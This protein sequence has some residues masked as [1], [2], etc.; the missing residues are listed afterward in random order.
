MAIGCW[1]RAASIGYSVVDPVAIE[2]SRVLFAAWLVVSIL[3]GIV[4]AFLAARRLVKSD[5]R[6]CSGRGA[7]R[8]QRRC[9]ISVLLG[10]H[11]KCA[12]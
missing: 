9:S 6:T 11:G 10:A 12:H 8:W 1:S 2:F 7:T 3:L 5:V 4:L